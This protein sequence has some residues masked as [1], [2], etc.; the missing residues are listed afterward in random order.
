[1]HHTNKLS[2]LYSMGVSRIKSV[3]PELPESDR[4][5][6]RSFTDAVFRIFWSPESDDPPPPA[7]GSGTG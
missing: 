5:L 7:E 3:K 2:H 1:M 4:P 6:S